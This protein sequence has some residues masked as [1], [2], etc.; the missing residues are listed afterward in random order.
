MIAGRFTQ[1]WSLLVATVVVVTGLAPVAGVAST[2]GR[3]NTAL[4]LTG[5][6]VYS[7]LK[8][9]GKTALVLGAGSAYAWKRAADSRKQDKQK[10]AYYRSQAAARNGRGPAVST[11][12]HKYHKHHRVSHVVSSHSKYYQAKAHK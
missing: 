11:K 1:A 6:T 3:K 2:K 10:Q 9:H 4:V 5:A 8:G 7:A 12:H